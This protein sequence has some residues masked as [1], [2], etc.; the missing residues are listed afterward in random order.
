[1]SFLKY[2]N[3]EPGPRTVDG[4]PIR[5]GER[6]RRASSLLKREEAEEL[7]ISFTAHC[8]VFDLSDPAQ[9][10]GY[11]QVLDKI[12][13]GMWARLAPDKEMETPDKA[14]WKVLCRWAEVNGEIPPNLLQA[15]GV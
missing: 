6:T 2:L 12:A 5:G 7:P 8:K 13:N 15:L 11:E 1:M 9:L 10:A 4:F 3:D 14:T